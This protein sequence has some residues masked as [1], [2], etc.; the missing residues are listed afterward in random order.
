MPAVGAPAATATADPMSMTPP[1][2]PGSFTQPAPDVQPPQEAQPA[3]PFQN[4]QTAPQQA[5]ADP[6]DVTPPP[7]PGGFP[8][9]TQEAQPNQE[10]PGAIPGTI[11][12]YIPPQNAPG[13]D[14]AAVKPVKPVKKSK[15]PLIIILVVVGV[16]L[17]GGVGA[18]FITLNNGFLYKS[19]GVRLI[20]N[21]THLCVQHHYADADCTHPETCTICGD[22]HGEPLGH[23]W[24]EA[25]CTAPKTCSECGET[26]GE[27]IPHTWTEATCT[28][29]R[30]CS[31]CGATDGEA[32]GHTTRLG[33]CTRCGE[34]C[35]ELRPQLNSISSYIMQGDSYVQTGSSYI[36]SV[37]NSYNPSLSDYYYAC[38]ESAT[39]NN[40]AYEQYNYAIQECGSEPEFAKLKSLL[41]D[42]TGCIPQSISGSSYNNILDYLQ[43]MVDFIDASDKCTKELQNLI[44][45]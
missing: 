26:E 8:Q 23:V 2:F 18:F 1:P 24:V 3:Q 9:A 30:T 34:V 33:K 44:N 6:M 14:G 10:I 37:T 42:M 31:V 39:Y 22:E 28:A 13:A 36:A 19:G 21:V 5:V 43:T 45:Y 12:G 29:P 40:Y 16:I 38:R 15:L 35:D 20:Y 17:L 41:K 7:F 27:P 11:P 25:T 32:L 4:E